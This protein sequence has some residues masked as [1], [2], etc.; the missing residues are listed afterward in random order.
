MH[1]YYL[2]NDKRRCMESDLPEY[3]EKLRTGIILLR[4]WLVSLC[5]Y[6]KMIAG[7]LN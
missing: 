1:T 3:L 6:S 5:L 2:T 7:G 4:T